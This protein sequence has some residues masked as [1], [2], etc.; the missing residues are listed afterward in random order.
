MLNLNKNEN[1]KKRTLIIGLDGAG[2]SHFAEEYCKDNGINA[3]VF[4]FNKTNFESDNIV[5]LKLNLPA[6]RL[7]DNI[8]GIIEDVRKSKDFNGVVFDD[9]GV[10]FEFLTG[11]GKD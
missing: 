5:E 11:K 2:K 10:L 9:V 4:D 6:F 8:K 1:K 3:V 7:L